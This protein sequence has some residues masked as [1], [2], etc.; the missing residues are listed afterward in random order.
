MECVLSS[1][2]NNVSGQLAVS[3]E[4]SRLGKCINI[5]NPGRTTNSKIINREF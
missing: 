3:A 5:N 1:E 2:K 4:V